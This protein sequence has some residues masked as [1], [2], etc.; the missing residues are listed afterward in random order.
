MTKESFLR[1]MEEVITDDKIE[2]TVE[3]NSC[4]TYTSEFPRVLGRGNPSKEAAKK[5]LFE[6]LWE[7][8]DFLYKHKEELAGNCQ[9][10]LNHFKKILGIT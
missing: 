10:D 8:F 1:K 3:G 9:Q 7:G 5:D 4:Y 2:F 6:G